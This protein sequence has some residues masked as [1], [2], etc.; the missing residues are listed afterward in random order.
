[1]ILRLRLVLS[2]TV[3]LESITLPSLILRKPPKGWPVCVDE[4]G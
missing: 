3:G 1:M 4:L 2:N